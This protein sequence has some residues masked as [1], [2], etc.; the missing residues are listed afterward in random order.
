MNTRNRTK[1]MHFDFCSH[2]RK[3]KTY[4]KMASDFCRYADVHHYTIV[5]ILFLHIHLK[6][7]QINFLSAKVNAVT[8]NEQTKKKRQGRKI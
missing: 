7:L 8:N 2:Q 5:S 3:R 1:K 6:I 4:I